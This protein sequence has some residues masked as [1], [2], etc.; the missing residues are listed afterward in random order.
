MKATNCVFVIV[1]AAIC[2]FSLGGSTPEFIIAVSL[3]SG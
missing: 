2:E 1:V 3:L